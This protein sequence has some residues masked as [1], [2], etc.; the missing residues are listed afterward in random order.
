[1]L[2]NKI[3]YLTIE[4]STTLK[5]IKAELLY[6]LSKLKNENNKIR[7][8]K[9]IGLRFIYYLTRP[10]YKNKHLWITFDKLYKAGDNGEY[11]YQY[12]LKHNKNIYY[13]IKKDSPDYKGLVKQN[14]KHIL[15]F[16][17]LKAKLMSLHAEVILKT[18][19]NLLGF[20]GFDGLAREMIRNLFNAEILEIQH[21]LTIQDIPEYQNR[22]VDNTK[23]YMIA[24]K[25][26]E[27]NIEKEEYGYKKEQIKLTGLA[28]YDGLK[29]NDKKIILI[30]PTWRH[31]VASPSIKHG[32]PRSHNDNFKN[33]DYFKIYN[34]LINNQKM[35]N[36]AKKNEYKII[37]LIHP[38]LSE[39]LSDFDKNDY[40]EIIPAA[41]DM[42]Y[43]NATTL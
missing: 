12:G 17:S 36:S 31:N 4:K 1:M 37:Y 35:I 6:D 7:V 18:H 16:N 2:K 34:S 41:G 22:L 14:K 27:K 23:M 28:R 5:V 42:S 32:V 10:F 40:V 13:I 19:A 15:I 38:T 43:E 9:L 11:I 39:Q 33:S 29:S 26:E 20:C 25:F 3:S 8:L 21:G 24:S 30:T